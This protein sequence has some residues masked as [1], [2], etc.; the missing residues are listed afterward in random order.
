MKKILFLALFAI[1]SFSVSAQEYN[2]QGFKLGLTAHPNFGWIK[3]DIQD[4]SSDGMRAGFTYGLLADFSFAENYTFSSGLML[5]T[6]NGQVE[7]RITGAAPETSQSIYKL[8]YIEIPAKIKLL[9]NETNGL[10]F[11]GE[12]GLGNGINVRAKQDVTS[13][14]SANNENDADIYKQIAFY[15]GSIILAGGAEISTT[16]KTKLLAG[17]TFNN[18]FTDIRKGEG[19][20][21]NSY[22]GLNL[23]V[24]F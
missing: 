2:E 8:Q 16:G 24:F 6:I 13:T 5:T 19:T 20:L 15:R 1:Y 12:F 23:G 21:K 3:S 14:I 18:G 10:K 7:K 9:T 4:I 22:I 17:L 11:F